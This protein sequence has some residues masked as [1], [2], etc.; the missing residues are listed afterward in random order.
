MTTVLALFET[1]HEA[2]LVIRSLIDIGVD[3]DEISLIMPDAKAKSG[4]SAASL[5]E[6]Q[7]TDRDVTTGAGAGAAAGGILGLLAGAGALAIP[8]IGPLIA[9]GPIAA[10]IGGAGFGA[11]AGTLGGTLHHL[12]VPADRADRF[13]EVLGRGG[14]LVHLKA[15]ESLTYQVTE[16]L[17]D[18]GALDVADRPESAVGEGDAAVHSEPGDRT[19]KR[20]EVRF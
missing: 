13:G 20:N 15:D 17:K 1:P 7:R 2:Q 9:A 14:A 12:G 10:S 6:H 11:I 5:D 18:H 16:T 8:G 19:Q 4:A 3:G